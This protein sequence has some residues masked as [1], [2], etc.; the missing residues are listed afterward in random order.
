MPADRLRFCRPLSSGQKKRF[1]CLSLSKYFKKETKGFYAKM[2]YYFCFL[3]SAG[4]TAAAYHGDLSGRQRRVKDR[5][6]AT[7]R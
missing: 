7:T 1:N 5:N 6:D 4:R 2:K 3:K